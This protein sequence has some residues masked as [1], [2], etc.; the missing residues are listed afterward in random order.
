M[1][2]RHLE[3]M[4]LSGRLQLLK[5]QMFILKLIHVVKVGN[6]KVNRTYAMQSIQGRTIPQLIVFLCSSSYS[7]SATGSDTKEKEHR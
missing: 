2:H 1:P 6:I 4:C 5:V 3:R 7:L